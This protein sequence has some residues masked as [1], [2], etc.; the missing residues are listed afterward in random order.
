MAP[1]AA[2]QDRLFQMGYNAIRQQLLSIKSGFLGEFPSTNIDDLLRLN[3]NAYLS[4]RSEIGEEWTRLWS[5][6]NTRYERLLRQQPQYTG[7]QIETI[8]IQE[9]ADDQRTEALRVR[10]AALAAL[11]ES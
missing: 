11:V 7:Y 10:D 6:G 9:A 5:E 2:I 3:N 1:M 8:R 4:R